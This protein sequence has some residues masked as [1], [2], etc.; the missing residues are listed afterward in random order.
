MASR[1]DSVEDFVHDLQA[2]G[3]QLLSQDVSQQYFYLLSL[4][5]TADVDRRRRRELP[6]LSL[7]PCLYKR[8]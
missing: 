1:F 7:K 6:E 3:F 2:Y 5:K 8:R 4:K